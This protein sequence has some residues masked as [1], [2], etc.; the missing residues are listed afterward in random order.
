LLDVLPPSLA[1]AADV[2]E[3]VARSTRTGHEIAMPRVDAEIDGRARSFRLDVVPLDHPMAAA[4]VHVEELT[5]AVETEAR[6]Q[7]N[8][9]LAQLG[10][11]S[12]AV[13]HELRN[14]LA[15][16][17]GALQVIGRS[18]ADDD[19]RK[20]IMEK[21]EGQVRRLNALV[22]DLLA[23]ARPDVARAQPVEL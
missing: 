2:A 6:L 7:R 11:L 21:V 23:F 19:R 9:S 1:E 12:A 17:S 20:A 18:L 14:P 13:A 8:E 3:L 5:E 10:T 16:I 22:T 15:G 4:L